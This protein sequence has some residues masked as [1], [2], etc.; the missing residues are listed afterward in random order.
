MFNISGCGS[1][2]E[3]IVANDKTTERN[4]PSAPNIRVSKI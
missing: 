3:H 1:I 2:V 4:R